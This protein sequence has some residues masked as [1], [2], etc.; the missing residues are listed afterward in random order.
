M[1][2]FPLNVSLKFVVIS[3]PTT[4]VALETFLIFFLIRVTGVIAIAMIPT[5]II[6][7][8]QELYNKTP[9]NPTIPKL[10]ITNVLIVLIIF[11]LAVSGSV[12]NL[13]RTKPEEFI[14]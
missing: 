3:P 4:I 12:K 11:L 10:V 2:L 7:S 1:I 8:F 13:V 6:A 9:T 14:S 5:P